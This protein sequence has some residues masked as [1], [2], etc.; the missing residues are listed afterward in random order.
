MCSDALTSPATAPRTKRVWK[1][2]DGV[3][4][5]DKPLGWTSNDALQRVRRLFSAAKGGHTGTL[6]PLATGLL[7]LCLGEATKF[8]ADLLNADKT[9]LA[10][11]RFGARSTTGDSEGDL[12]DHRSC[13][14]LTEAAL[15]SAASRFQGVIQQIPPMYSALKR[16][17]KPLYELARQGIEVE[18]QPREITIHFNRLVSF[19][20]DP[21]AA[22]AVLEV[23]CSKGTYIR[24]LAEDMG[25]A[26]GCGA[27][28]VGLRRTAVAD[29][30]LNGCI[31]FS[32]LEQ[33]SEEERGRFL[34]PVD[35]LLHSLP[36]VALGEGE[37]REG[38]EAQVTRFTC[39]NPVTM[40][41]PDHVQEAGL[42][43]V[44]YA[45]K[46]LGTGELEH[47]ASASNSG[48]RQG[49]LKPKRLLK[50]D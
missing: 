5:L 18:R 24:T 26:L 15:E 11:V 10:H 12:M 9:Y 43:R 1:A 45:G 39:G 19:T 6:D 29:L 48:G 20:P 7:P 44:Y 32:T 25:E 30:T 41:W 36:M 8:S 2:V 38:G 46:L 40:T 23:R 13:D 14:A 17:G 21:V 37:T 22:H 4:F 49:V 34:A 42:V 3:V 35:A 33:A 31:E 16:D 50:K 28:L 47:L 27:H